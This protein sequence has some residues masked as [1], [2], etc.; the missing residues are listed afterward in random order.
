MLLTTVGIIIDNLICCKKVLPAKVSVVIRMVSLRFFNL[1]MTSF[2]TSSSTAITSNAL[3]AVE[4]FSREPRP[5][6]T[7]SASS[8]VAYEEVFKTHD[9]SLALC[10][11]IV[12]SDVIPNLIPRSA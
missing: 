6:I 10:G 11:E 12:E 1:F 8:A 5:L 2:Q 3:N 9:L 7:T 4:I